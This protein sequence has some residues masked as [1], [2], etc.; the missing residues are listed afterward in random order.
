MS[1]RADGYRGV[2]TIEPAELAEAM[3][4]AAD[5][6]L[7]V[8]VHAIGD[9]AVRSV[10]DTYEQTRVGVPAARPAHAAHRARPA[11]PSRRCA[12]LRRARRRRLDAADPRHVGLARSG[13]ALGRAGA[14]RVRLADAAAAGA[15]L[16]FGTDAPVEGLEPLASL[17]AA[18]DAPGPARR[19]ARRLVSRTGACRSR[20][21]C[22]AY[23]S[24]SA[25]AER[26]S[27]RRGS[28]GLARMPTW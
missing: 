10:L 17:Y 1:G 14:T 3:R 5:A 13:Y 12:A 6:E 26:A 24:G 11:R 16:A 4:L 25:A 15:T 28:L 23:T 18:V 8:A 7:D 27:T 20:K 22:G 19:A 2:P 21:P 9:A